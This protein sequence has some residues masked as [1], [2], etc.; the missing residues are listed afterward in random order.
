MIFDQ[1]ASLAIAQKNG[2]NN[3]NW[4]IYRLFGLSLASNFRLVKR[5]ALLGNNAPD[6]IFSHKIVESLPADWKD[7]SPSYISPYKTED[8]RS[9]LNVYCKS[10]H[11][12]MCFTDIA[13]FYL[14]DDRIECYQLHNVNRNQVEMWFVGVVLSLW[15]EKKGVPVIHASS[16]VVNDCAIAFMNDSTG[17]KSSLAASLVNSGYQL[18][19]DDALAIKRAGKMFIGQPGYPQMRLWPEIAELFMDNIEELEL[20]DSD[21]S[22]RIVPVSTYGFGEF[23]DVPK[24]INCIYIPSRQDP[25][26]VGTDVKIIQVSPL[27]ATIELVRN[28]FLIRML[29]SIGLQPKRLNFLVDIAKTIPMRRIIYPSNLELLPLICEKILDDIRD[30]P[31]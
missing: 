4:M 27:D 18:L 26:G 23:C 13:D 29:S 1:N 31:S 19:T 12:V 8:G 20:V 10:E 21:F 3:C 15:L 5:V 25:K 17:G 2:F 30:I 16:V 22:K 28:S 11:D 24:S 14:W 6:V 7:I 9:I